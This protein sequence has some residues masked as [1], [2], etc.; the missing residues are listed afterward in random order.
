MVARAVTSGSHMLARSAQRLEQVDGIFLGHSYSYNHGAI[1]RNSGFCVVVVVVRI[2]FSLM[3]IGSHHVIY[4][5]R[6]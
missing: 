4:R 2:A 3:V 6:Q 5:S 1:T